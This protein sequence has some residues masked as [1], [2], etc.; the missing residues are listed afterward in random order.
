MLF[1]IAQEKWLRNEVEK[2]EPAMKSLIVVY[3][4]HHNNTQKVAEAFAKVL[5]AQIKTP[6]QI[7]PEELQDYDLVGFGS[8]IDSGKNYNELLDFA[9]RLPQVS[10]T[11]RHLYSQP[12]ECQS[13]FQV[14]SDWKSTQANVIRPLKKLF[15][16]KA[17]RLLMSLVVR[18]STLTSFSNIL[19]D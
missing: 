18:V 1:V 4:Y 14:N 8:G 13:A 3:S 6:Q 19:V 2:E 11:R 12:L 16:L 9:E 17:T 15:N 7:N 10:Q 5:D